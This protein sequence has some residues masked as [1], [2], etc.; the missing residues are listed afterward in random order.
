MEGKARKQLFVNYPP[1]RVYVSASRINCAKGGDFEK[2]K[3]ETG[4]GAQAYCWYIWE[5][6]FKGDPVL[7]WIN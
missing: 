6:G 1:I 4:Q 7:K 3:K 5:K 2:F